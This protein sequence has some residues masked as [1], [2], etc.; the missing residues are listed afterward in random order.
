MQVRMD[1]KNGQALSALG[2]GVMRLPSRET[3]DEAGA[4]ALLRAAID[5]GVTYFDTALAYGA[6]RNEALL[7]K[8]LAGGWRAKATVATKLP[9]YMVGKLEAAKKMFATELARLQTDYVDVYLMHM[10]MDRAM[11][12]RLAALGI[13][14]WLEGL[15]RE[16]VVRRI[17]FSFH[18]TRTD[19]EALIRAYPWDI[20]QIQYN[21]L[22]ENS[23]AT[24]EG[25]RLAAGLGIPVVV[26][27]PLRGGQLVANLPEEVVAAFAAA[28][29]DWT[30][31]EWALRW[32]W[33]QPE[34]T[35][36][37]SGMAD[38]KQLAENARIADEAKAGSLT[39]ADL[40]VFETVKAILLAKTVVPC[41][42]CGYCMPCPYGVDIPGCFQQLNDK[43][44]TK[45]RGGV[46]KYAQAL[47]A[48]SKRPGFASRCT[49]C[50]KCVPKCPQRIAIPQELKRVAREMEGPLFKPVVGA[51][52]FFMKAGKTRQG[53]DAAAGGDAHG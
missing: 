10:L 52:R 34:V 44:R 16:G 18:G 47:G 5:A 46:F 14:E 2:F 25:L 53:E 35:V 12:D 19:F 4:V 15:K 42:A 40:A 9:P 8:A 11:F 27:E 30:P 39:E 22:D 38:A 48:M 29:P 41:T 7:G 49:A 37:L 3:P 6:G 20:V 24:R 43:H 32:L 28:H 51:A 17:G 33:N 21:Y 36:V 31:A 50:N 23:Q 45:A 1:P 13:F 26:M